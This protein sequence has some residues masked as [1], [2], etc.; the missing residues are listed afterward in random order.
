MPIPEN[1]VPP[2]PA[3]PVSGTPTHISY[4]GNKEGLSFVL[5]AMAVCKGAADLKNEAP[6]RGVAES[7]ARLVLDHAS[8][9]LNDQG[10]AVQGNPNPKAAWLWLW[11]R[12]RR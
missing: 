3:G 11:L 8:Q 9:M 5:L 4:Q 1:I 10:F 6:V 12:V 7:I 2:L